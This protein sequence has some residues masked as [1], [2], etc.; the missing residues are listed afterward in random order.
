MKLK[1]LKKII[2]EG[3]KP[4]TAASSKEVREKDFKLLIKNKPAD[5]LKIVPGLIAVQ[6]TGGGKADQ[7]FLRG[8]DSDHG[9]DI[10]FFIDKLPIN[11]R[12]HA[13]GQGY[14]DLNFIIPETIEL[15]E[16]FKGNYYPQFGDFNNAGAVRFVTKD[17]VPEGY[18][19]ASSGLYAVDRFRPI[20]RGPGYVL[21]SS[22]RY[23]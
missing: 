5:L 14:T 3:R 9:T 19:Q 17:F 8:F 18:V 4:V 23:C 2:V 1:V 7:Y 22:N 16:V 20:A 15:V 6:H 10:A 21:P 13:H 12:S 11:L